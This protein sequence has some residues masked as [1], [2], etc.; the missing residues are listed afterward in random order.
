LDYQSQLPNR[1]PKR[2]YEAW[3]LIALLAMTIP[4]GAMLLLLLWVVET[5]SGGFKGMGP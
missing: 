1:P 2:W 5:M 4:V 3:W